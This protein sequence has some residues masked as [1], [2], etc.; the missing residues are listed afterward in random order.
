MHPSPTMARALAPME[1]C[2]SAF[3]KM[4]FVFSEK[5]R[6]ALMMEVTAPF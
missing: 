6:E 3:M 2:E 5:Q 1:S 4:S